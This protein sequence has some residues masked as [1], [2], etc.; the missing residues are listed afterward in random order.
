[1]NDKFDKIRIGVL[2]SGGGTNLEAIF[3]SI[4]S[5]DLIHGEVKLVISSKAD[6]FALERAKKRNIRNLYIEKD[7]FEKAVLQL[8]E[9]EKIDMVVLAGFLKVLSGDFIKRFKKPIINIHPSLIPAFCGKGCYGIKVHEQALQYGVKVTG[10]TVH[11]V[12]EVVDGGKIIDQKA[13]MIRPEDDAVSL[14]KR[15]M[16]EAEWIILPRAI[17]NISKQ[18]LKNRS[19]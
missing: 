8:F 18:I 3:K 6:A 11:F 16:E 13:V 7:G 9:E 2:V 5:G 1:M 12:S 10:A 15:V 17:E 4:D 14:Q 19:K